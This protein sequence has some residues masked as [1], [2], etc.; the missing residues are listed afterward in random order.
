M[1]ELKC[2][3]KTDLEELEELI[4]EAK[5]ILQKIRDFKVEVELIVDE[6]N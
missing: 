3:V 2:S 6:A 1:A 5:I 4:N